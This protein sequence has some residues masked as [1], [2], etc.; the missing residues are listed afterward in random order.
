MDFDFMFSLLI[1]LFLCLVPKPWQMTGFDIGCE[2]VKH[3]L[4]IIIAELQR[5]EVCTYYKLEK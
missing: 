1:T 2:D 5:K 4:A 3:D